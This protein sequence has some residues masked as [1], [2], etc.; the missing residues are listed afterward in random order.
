MAQTE[1]IL[2][3]LRTV[4]DRGMCSVEPVKWSPPILRTAARISDLKA[5]GHL[6]VAHPCNEGDHGNTTAVR[7]TLVTEP[8]GR[9]L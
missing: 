4:G 6:I 9:L 5:A 1:R 8:Q 2:T 3:R 7:Y